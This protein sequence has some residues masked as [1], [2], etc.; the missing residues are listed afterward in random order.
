MTFKLYN[1][2]SDINNKTLKINKL[3]LARSLFDKIQDPYMY[4][5]LERF[6]VESHKSME[7]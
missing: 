3:K 2:K 1:F 7:K 5:R 6:V 4:F